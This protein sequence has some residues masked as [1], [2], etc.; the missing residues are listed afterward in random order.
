METPSDA[1]EDNLDHPMGTPITPVTTPGVQGFSGASNGDSTTN[2][3]P[4]AAPL[5]D[6]EGD[7]DKPRPAKRPR[8]HSDADE[9]SIAHVSFVFPVRPPCGVL[10][11]WS[12]LS[13]PTT[14][15]PPSPCD[16]ASDSHLQA[17][18]PPPQHQTA[19][20]PSLL[21][22]FQQHSTQTRE[23]QRWERH[24]TSSACRQ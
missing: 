11:N 7:D 5:D 18:L 14:L 10:I 2:T 22:P 3:T 13:F 23:S 20:P 8:V 17:L 6:G 15:L 24:N 12:V 9:A 1:Q 4:N 19:Q 21:P 16:V